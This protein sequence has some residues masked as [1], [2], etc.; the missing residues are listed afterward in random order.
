MN[1]GILTTTAAMLLGVIIS[2]LGIKEKENGSYGNIDV[3]KLMGGAGITV[4]C[5]I[6]L[7]VQIAP[8]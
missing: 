7:F 1:I 2:I 4:V 8:L 6:M 5:A 3:L